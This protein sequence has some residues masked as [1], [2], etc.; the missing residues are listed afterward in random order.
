MKKLTAAV[1][2]AVLLLSGCTIDP[3]TTQN[4]QKPEAREYTDSAAEVEFA[5]AKISDDGKVPEY[6]GPLVY[7]DFSYG[8]TNF[9]LEYPP[10]ENFI[11]M[12]YF[13]G[14]DEN[15]DWTGGVNG[16][17]RMEEGDTKK[18]IL[19]KYGAEETPISYLTDKQ[20]ILENLINNELFLANSYHCISYCDK[21]Y[22]IECGS[23]PFQQRA[24][25]RFYFDSYDDVALVTFNINDDLILLRQIDEGRTLSYEDYGFEPYDPDGETLIPRVMLKGMSA[26]EQLHTDLSYPVL[27]FADGVMKIQWYDY[28]GSETEGEGLLKS[29]TELKYTLNGCNIDLELPEG[30][31]SMDTYIS[32]NKYLGAYELHDPYWRDNYGCTLMLGQ[33]V[34]QEDVG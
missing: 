27:R 13:S 15:G 28:G 31:N 9:F 34:Q 5:S 19:E 7:K 17:V 21:Y 11:T 2:A 14:Y 10:N 20:C 12:V 25:I 29:G 32:F 23:L 3:K 1:M 6:G 8:D 22:P 26:Y 16:L 24:S 33:A 18:N 30:G 4:K